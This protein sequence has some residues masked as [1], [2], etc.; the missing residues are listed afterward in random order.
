M[1]SS[2]WPGH[3]STTARCRHVCR[4]HQARWLSLLHHR[5]DRD[6]PGSAGRPTSFELANPLDS[7]RG[8]STLSD[9]RYCAWF[10]TAHTRQPGSLRGND[11]CLLRH[12]AL[13]LARREGATAL[14]REP[15]LQP[16]A[17]PEIGRQGL[18]GGGFEAQ[19]TTRLYDG[20]KQS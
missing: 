9:D 15:I 12:P 19:E 10:S 4:H 7:G 20:G 8:E 2:F 1:T 14:D 13:W 3:I 11:V 6:P 16:L 17:G 5:R 18:L